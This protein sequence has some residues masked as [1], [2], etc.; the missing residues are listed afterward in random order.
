M[1]LKYNKQQLKIL[2]DQYKKYLEEYTKLF[3]VDPRGVVQPTTTYIK[4][5]VTIYN[6]REA[7]TLKQKLIKYGYV[8]KHK[9]YCDSETWAYYFNGVMV[10]EINVYYQYLFEESI[11]K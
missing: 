8:V 1:K 7:E 10:I 4:N 3:N 11:K 5:Y 2:A 9:L 6:K